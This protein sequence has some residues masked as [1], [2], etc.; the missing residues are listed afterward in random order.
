[1]ESWN[2]GETPDGHY[3]VTVVLEDLD[4]NIL[5]TAGGYFTIG[6]DLADICTGDSEADG[7][8]DGP[9]LAAYIDRGNFSTM[10]EFAATYGSL[11]P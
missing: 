10:V 11:C 2:T 1:M 9:D 3:R 7:D 5:D 8:V 6:A 4:G